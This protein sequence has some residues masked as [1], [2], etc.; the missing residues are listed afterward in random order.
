MRRSRGCSCNNGLEAAAVI[1]T[2]G[3]PDK[4]LPS[5]LLV[6]LL[7]QPRVLLAMARDGLLPEKFFGAVHPRFPHA[8]TKSTMLTGA[9]A[10][11]TSSLLAPGGS[12]AHG[13][14][15]ERCSRFVRG[16]RRG[17]DHCA[18]KKPLRAQ[19]AIFRAPG[20]LARCSRRH[21]TMPGHDG[22][23]RLG[24]TGCVCWPG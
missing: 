12:R 2:I 6:M 10:A 21:R 20:D 13:P 23:P 4:A 5:V 1:I 7:S 22:V 8:R 14:A 9:F 24:K 19:A 18:T 16:L 3:R 11:V 15:S 17:V